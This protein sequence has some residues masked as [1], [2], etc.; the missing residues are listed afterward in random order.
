LQHLSTAI[1]SLPGNAHRDLP[2]DQP[3]HPKYQA[4]IL[5]DLDGG[6]PFLIKNSKAGL[7]RIQKASPLSIVISI[8]LSTGSVAAIAA[9]VRSV[10][11]IILD[12]QRIR[13]ERALADRAVFRAL[14]E[15]L[16]LEK[17]YVKLRN[18]LPSEDAGRVL[19]DNMAGAMAGLVDGRYPRIGTMRPSIPK[20]R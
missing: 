12:M 10:C 18:S 17:D 16:L 7:V 14:R 11:R 4:M 20:R 19:D 9:V 13:R 6:S 5:A 3:F 15:R 1:S 8:F 2:P